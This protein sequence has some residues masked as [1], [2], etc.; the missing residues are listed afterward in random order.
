MVQ[1]GGSLSS[2]SHE[3][4]PPSSFQT[5]P[6]N[7]AHA[8]VPIPPIGVS[9][10][11]SSRFIVRLLNGRHLQVY[12]C[13][14]TSN[15]IQRT[16]DIIRAKLFVDFG[17]ASRIAALFSGEI[18][19]VLTDGKDVRLALLEPSL[20]PQGRQTEEKKKD[21]E[22]LGA[23]GLPTIEDSGSP[24][25]YAKAKNL[26][27]EFLSTYLG[28]EVFGIQPGFQCP[29]LYLFRGPFQTTLAVST[30]ILLLERPAALALIKEKITQKEKAFQGGV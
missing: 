26:F 11:F 4:V 18:V 23:K 7:F 15:G 9:A 1:A 10:S 17:I 28:V 19:R 12:L 2:V 22:V 3:G 30:D 21:V 27:F 29:D 8:D 16:F 25:L 24:I 14:Y 13:A 20:V 5:L 6:C